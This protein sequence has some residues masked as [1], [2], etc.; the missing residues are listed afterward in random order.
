MKLVYHPS[1]P[2]L[3][4][5]H[6]IL[7]EKFEYLLLNEIDAQPW[8]NQLKRRVQQYG[9]AYNYSSKNILSQKIDDL[10]PGMNL[11]LDNFMCLEHNIPRPN[12]CIVNEYTKNQGIS[13]HIDH[14][15]FGPTIMSLTLNDGANMIF[16]NITT[17]Q[18][19][20]VWLPRRSLAILQY[21][22]RYKFKH[23]IPT[24]LTM[25][26]SDY[27][28]NNSLYAMGYPSINFLKDDN[29]RR[30]SVTFRTVY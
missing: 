25:T 7:T 15:S 3:T 17:G 10:L 9:Y 21:D 16:I 1:I 12:Q 30:V 22:A 20:S 2:G 24:K 26:V 29:Y 11:F 27:D 6:N 23:S 8:S 19:Y 4:L 14:T 18:E 5:I 13:P 28:C